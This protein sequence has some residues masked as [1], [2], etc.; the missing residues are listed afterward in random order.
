MEICKIIN[1]NILELDFIFSVS[2]SLSHQ[3]HP[4]HSIIQ[5]DTQSGNYLLY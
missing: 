1:I 5:T 3:S 4:S 2:L